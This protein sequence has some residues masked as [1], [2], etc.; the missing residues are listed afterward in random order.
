MRE[1]RSVVVVEFTISDLTSGGRHFQ[2]PTLGSATLTGVLLCFPFLT[3][4]NGRGIIKT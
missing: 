2:F 1:E 4:P 3:V